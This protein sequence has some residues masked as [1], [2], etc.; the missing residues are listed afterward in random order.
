[1]KKCKACS[2]ENKLVRHHIR[3]KKYGAKKDRVISLCETCHNLFHKHV[4][5]GNDK[6]LE[7]LTK[8]FIEG[9][10]NWKNGKAV[11]PGI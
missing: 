2:S 8:L 9:S 3:Y 5:K 7:E 6:Y 1:M 4:A 11:K 10:L